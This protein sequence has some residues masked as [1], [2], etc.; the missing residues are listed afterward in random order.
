MRHGFFTMGATAREAYERM[1]EFVTLA[2]ERLSKNRKPLAQAALPEKLASVAE[3]APILRGAV[4]I[5]RD[6]LAGTVK[7]QIL[8]FR[9]S[10]AILNYV[11]G[12]EL[13]RY[14]Q[15]GVVTPDHTIRT[16][17]WPLIVP[18][19]EAGKLHDWKSAVEHAVAAYV[20]RYHDYFA[21]N[22]AKSAQKKIE[23]DPLAAR[24]AGAR[25]RSL[26]SR[27]L[28]ERCRHCR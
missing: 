21:R 24:G 10:D 13:A 27:R 18:A 9:T 17:N 3:I 1:I 8:D 22:N 19:P 2:E 4:A 26:R 12:A 5:A 28:R 7:R 11:N 15:I 23:L 16:K 20:A 14:S 25:C 6:E